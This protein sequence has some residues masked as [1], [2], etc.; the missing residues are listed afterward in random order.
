MENG[1]KTKIHGSAG[2]ALGLT[3]YIR[4]CLE[5]GQLVQICAVR[6]QNHTHKRGLITQKLPNFS[7]NR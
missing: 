7:G 1:L 6:M 4:E 5:R 2:L 3:R